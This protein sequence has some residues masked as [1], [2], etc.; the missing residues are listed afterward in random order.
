MPKV[1]K[2]E[3]LKSFI[4]LNSRYPRESEIYENINI[5]K[6]IYNQIKYYNNGHYQNLKDKSEFETLPRFEF[7][8][9]NYH[10]LHGDIF[11]YNNKHTY[12]SETELHKVVIDLYLKENKNDTLL[13]YEYDIIPGQNFMGKGDILFYNSSVNLYTVI[14]VKLHSVNDVIRQARY[15]S[16]FVKLRNKNSRTRYCYIIPKADE[17]GT[18]LPIQFE[19]TEIDLKSAYKIV[20]TK[21]KTMSCI[22]DSVIDQLVNQYFI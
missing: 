8:A 17:N 5:G 11:V 14:E 3:L 12:K 6:W 13:D 2:I 21:L 18:P 9:K 10:L 16:A 22:Q 1:N 4:H 7:F 15:Y 19:Y 20:L